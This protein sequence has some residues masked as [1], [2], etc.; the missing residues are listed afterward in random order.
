MQLKCNSCNKVYGYGRYVK[1]F[2]CSACDVPLNHLKDKPRII[3]VDD[4]KHCRL[5]MEEWP[6]QWDAEMDIF[7]NAHDALDALSNHPYHLCIMDLMMHR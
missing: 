3:A 6:S 5:V 1:W 4:E 7:S 2:Q